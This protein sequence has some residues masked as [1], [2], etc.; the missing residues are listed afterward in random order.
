MENFRVEI[1]IVVPVYRVEPYLRDCLNSIL[2]QSFTAFELILVDDG[3]PD[4]SGRICD[5]YALQDNRVRVL[6]QANGGVTAARRNGLRLAVGEY[7]CFVDADDTLPRHALQNLHA[8]VREH[9]LDIG[10]GGFEEVDESGHALKQSFYPAG[11]Y[12]GQTFLEGLLSGVYGMPWATLYRRELFKDEE[13]MSVPPDIKRGEDL[14]MKMYLALRAKRV[15]GLPKV[16]YNYL[17]RSDSAA[18]VNRLAFVVTKRFCTYISDLFTR[19]GRY[20]TFEK[21]LVCYELAQLRHVLIDHFDPCDEWLL[22][23][24]QQAKHLS[25]PFK[26]RFVLFCATHKFAHTI[27]LLLH[28]YHL[29][30]RLLGK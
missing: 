19:S 30:D 27:I 8:F 24:K 2:C 25:L 26:Q 23:L 7:I 9:D 16:V 14:I 28:K 29:K 4:G 1:S 10:M 6:H 13:V 18:R 21:K 11:I 5:E 20:Q 22:R 3:S 12:S 17:Q 15:G